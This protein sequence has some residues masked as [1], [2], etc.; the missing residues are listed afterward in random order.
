[1]SGELEVGGW[2]VGERALQVE[3]M[4]QQSLIVEKQQLSRAPD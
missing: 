4:T 3:A 1:M 2:Q